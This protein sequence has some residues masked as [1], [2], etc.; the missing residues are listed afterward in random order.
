M[1]DL[2]SAISGLIRITAAM[3]TA[4]QNLRPIATAHYMSAILAFERG[5]VSDPPDAG[6]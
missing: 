2:C 3:Q 1:T 4:A 6:L 5:S